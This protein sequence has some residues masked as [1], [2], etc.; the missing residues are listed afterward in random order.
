MQKVVSVHWFRWF[1]SAAIWETFGMLMVWEPQKRRPTVKRL[2]LSTFQRISLDLLLMN[3][4][5]TISVP[6]CASQ[7]QQL[8]LLYRTT[9]VKTFVF[10]G[11]FVSY[12]SVD[13]TKSSK[14]QVCLP[15]CCQMIFSVMTASVLSTDNQFFHFCCLFSWEE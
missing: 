7:V 1:H 4:F 11:P 8:R 3:N 2:H 14:R 12:R 9:L 5:L 13:K 10:R 15:S 6:W